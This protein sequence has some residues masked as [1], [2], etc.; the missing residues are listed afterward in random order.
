MTNIQALSS[1]D[2]LDEDQLLNINGAHSTAYWA[3]HYTGKAV[4]AGLAV[5]AAVGLI[6]WRQVVK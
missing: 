1:F 5:T 3:G 2:E 4:I 6:I